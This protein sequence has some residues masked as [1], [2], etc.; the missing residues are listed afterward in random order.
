VRGKIVAT[1]VERPALIVRL[2]ENSAPLTAAAASQF[3]LVHN[4]AYAC[5]AVYDLAG[6]EPQADGL[7][8]LNL[9]MPLVVARGVVGSVASDA[10]SFASRT[11]VMKLRVNPGLFNG[12]RVRPRLANDTPEHALKTASE[13][14]FALADAA[15]LADFPVGGEYVV[16]DVGAGDTVEIV[17][18]AALTR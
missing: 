16:L 14:A 18:V 4:D 12:K 10:G 13:S 11:P 17:S 9:T 5:P 3:A 6:V 7:W 2:D 1:D 15:G 8:R